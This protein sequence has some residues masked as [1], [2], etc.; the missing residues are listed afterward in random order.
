MDTNWTPTVDRAHGLRYLAI[1]R[2]LSDD[3]VSGRLAEDARLPTQ[4]DLADQLGVAIGTVTRA[5]AEA[6]RRGLIRGEGR[7]GTFVGRSRTSRSV[8]ARMAGAAPGIDLSRNHPSY[9]L[10]PQLPMALRQLAREQNT[11][12]LLEYAPASGLM[13]HREAGA[14]WLSEL[15]SSTEPDSVFVTAGAQHALSAVFA[16]ETRPGDVV[17]AERYTYPGVKAIAELLDLQLI[18]IAT[19][20]EGI[21]PDALENACRQK[22]IRLLYCNPSLQN[23]TTSIS[24]TDRRRQIASVAEKYGVTVVE[25]EIMRPLLEDHPG[26]ITSFIPEQ[27]YLVISASKAV[28]AGLRVGFVQTP[29]VARQKML[30]S[31]NASSLGSP[32]LM[33]EL[34]IMWLEDGTADRVIGRR[35]HETAARQQLAADILKGMSFQGHPAAYHVWLELPGNWTGMK[36]AMEAQRRGVVLSPAEVFAIDRKTPAQAV[37]ISVAVPP[38]KEMLTSGLQ[39]VVD[40]LRGSADPNLAV[41]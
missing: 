15:G 17:A 27:S 16:A 23:P 29:I 40:L 13:R 30:E 22:T 5:Y 8:L 24:S 39:T 28:A 12:R 11:Q 9:S 4:R 38:T 21:I 31:L 1:V 36:L 3:I 32:S 2:A 7:R 25:D 19:D 20:N 35:R 33:T 37:R 14:R 41:V 6:E 10:D 18:G 34:L 26:F